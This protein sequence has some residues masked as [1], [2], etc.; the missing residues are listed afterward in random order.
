M[1]QILIIVALLMLIAGVTFDGCGCGSSKKGE[2]KNP[3]QVGRQFLKE[4]NVDAGYQR[5]VDLTLE[6]GVLKTGGIEYKV[7]SC[8]LLP[9]H[10]VFAS[11]QK[12]GKFLVARSMHDGVHFQD[13]EKWWH[14]QGIYM[15]M[16]PNH[17]IGNGTMY[18]E[19][20]PR[21]FKEGG[22]WKVVCK[23]KNIS[24]FDMQ[25]GKIE[26]DIKD[27]NNAQL[28]HHEINLRE[29][30]NGEE[31]NIE[32]IVELGFFGIGNK[33]DHIGNIT[34]RASLYLN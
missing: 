4:H 16:D 5:P 2:N 25:L 15:F 31:A 27:V 19:E 17:V 20:G 13:P 23:V 11:S 8:K 29:L 7:A 14:E 34:A 9:E 6:K 22:V 28:K 30:K 33:F 12:D 3:V 10:I 21:V 26:F 32:E 18:V 24:G 1:K